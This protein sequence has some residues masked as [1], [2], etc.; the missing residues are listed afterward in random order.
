[1][2]YIFVF[3][4]IALMLSCKKKKNEAAETHEPD[5]V[6]EIV[7]FDIE[8]DL[9]MYNKTK[10]D[11]SY[12][13]PLDADQDGYSDF[14]LTLT[15]YSTNR[16]TGGHSPVTNHWTDITISSL[17]AGNHIGS[18]KDCNNSS[19]VPYA[20]FL[21]SGQVINNSIV[22]FNMG[23]G[24][25][26]KLYN[27]VPDQPLL[28][29]T[30]TKYIPLILNQKYFAWIKVESFGRSGAKVIVKSVGFNKTVLMPVRAGEGS[31]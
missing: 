19:C 14:L 22:Y 15:T 25:D 31:S 8:P 10:V 17:S 2:K 1:V 5:P 30:G 28:D 11:T 3:I 12:S 16:L 23:V 24:L 6:A 13:K 7:S 26:F 9:T 21:D 4:A 20:K 27:G 29:V 18:F